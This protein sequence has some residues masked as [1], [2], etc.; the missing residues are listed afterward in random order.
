LYH[1]ALFDSALHFQH[2]NLVPNRILV[3]KRTNLSES[4]DYWTNQA[5]PELRSPNLKSIQQQF[6]SFTLDGKSWEI[7][8]EYSFLLSNFQDAYIHVNSEDKRS[9]F[10]SSESLLSSGAVFPFAPPLSVFLRKSAWKWINCFDSWSVGLLGISILDGSFEWIQTL[11]SIIAQNFGQDQTDLGIR[12]RDPNFRYPQL[13]FYVVIE[14]IFDRKLSKSL[15][16]LRRHLDLIRVLPIEF[17]PD[18]GSRDN[19]TSSAFLFVSEKSGFDKHAFTV[20]NNES[21]QQE[22]KRIRRTIENP[23][24]EEIQN[25]PSNHKRAFGGAF[26]FLR[27][28]CSWNTHASLGSGTLRPRQ[29]LSYHNLLSHPMFTARFGKVTTKINVLPDPLIEIAKV[30]TQTQ[31]EKVTKQTSSVSERTIAKI[32][33]EIVPSMVT[34]PVST[35][36]LE[37]KLEPL[38]DQELKPTPEPVVVSPLKSRKDKTPSLTDFAVHSEDAKIARRKLEKDLQTTAMEINSPPPDLSLPLKE[39][40]ELAEEI[41][42]PVDSIPETETRQ[43]ERFLGGFL[44]FWRT[45]LGLLERSGSRLDADSDVL[46]LYHRIR[47]K[48]HPWLIGKEGSEI[49]KAFKTKNEY[50][51][52]TAR[53]SWHINMLS[54][55]TY[56][57]GVVS[58]ISK[59]KPRIAMQWIADIMTENSTT[60]KLDGDVHVYVCSESDF[61]NLP[62]VLEI[63]SNN[64]SGG[65]WTFEQIPFSDLK[66]VW[67]CEFVLKLK[68]PS[69]EKI[70]VLYLRS[71]SKTKAIYKSF[72]NFNISRENVQ[73][74]VEMVGISMAIS[75][76][77]VLRLWCTG[78][79][80]SSYKKVQEV[81]QLLS[82][83][84]DRNDAM[85][86]IFP[87]L[88]LLQD[89]FS[90][91]ITLHGEF[92]IQTHPDYFK[93]LFS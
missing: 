20:I 10:K 72:G 74:L 3:D 84:V 62:S 25:L 60:G 5:A 6:S 47:F 37:H 41:V 34:Q 42:I 49:V 43:R 75:N 65:K 11:N 24:T 1:L 86:R 46:S 48:I 36:D 12:F 29:Q 22:I 32:A 23:L 15:K 17:Q 56:F 57:I 87:L 30:A 82:K 85:Q 16:E 58:F 19:F 18:P 90:W 14:N 54:P 51:D 55:P 66:F 52:T 91:H 35:L 76:W 71:E 13:L 81:K 73:P 21:L 59:V 2:R 27:R 64:K 83:G 79:W 61:L 77:V 93:L 80:N 7:D 28:L 44:D 31:M 26:D 53:A 67:K 9:K 50:D 8:S 40:R 88:L 89:W 4:I 45:Y 39:F 78:K 63:Q 70:G 38:P 69:N 33:E 92:P 68:R